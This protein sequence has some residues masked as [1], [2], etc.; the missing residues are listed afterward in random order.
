[1]DEKVL[2]VNTHRGENPLFVGRLGQFLAS[3]DVEHDVIEGYE[4]LNPLDLGAR[5]II[6]TGVPIDAS[7]SLAEPETQ[8]L[9]D[10]TFG[11]LRE[12][13]RPVLGI[14]YGHQILAQVFGGRVSSLEEA[15]LDARC[16]LVLSREGGIFSGVEKLKVFAEHRDYVSVVPGGF[17]VLSQR[18]GIPYIMYDPERE[19]YGVQFVPEQSG[20]RSQEILARFVLE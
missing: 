16:P 18:N 10:R 5:R 4:G 11:W 9:I 6:L 1:M 14:C 12:C 3:R 17:T 15:V 7:Y 2:I 8:K 13:G 20:A 19:M